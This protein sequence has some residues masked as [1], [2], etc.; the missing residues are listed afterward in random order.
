MDDST[1]GQYGYSVIVPEVEALPAGV[2]GRAAF[3]YL[4]GRGV[5][6]KK[7]LVIRQGEVTGINNVETENNANVIRYNVAGQRVLN[8]KGLVISKNGKEFVK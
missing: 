1:R 2:E 6:S 4:E 7:P 3:I 8:A 5:K